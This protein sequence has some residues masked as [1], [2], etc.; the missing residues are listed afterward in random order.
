MLQSVHAILLLNKLFVL[1]LRDNIPTIPA[2][3]KWSLFGGKI[4]AYE[5]PRSAIEREIQEEL[6]ITPPTYRFFWSTEYFFK[7]QKVRGRI[8]FF[9]ANANSVWSEHK[10]KEGQMVKA[11]SFND[12]PVSKMPSIMFRALKRFHRS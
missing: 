4:N 5:T 12:L 11:F 1:Q 7:F 10:L 6:L 8:W 9:I 3:G 2:P